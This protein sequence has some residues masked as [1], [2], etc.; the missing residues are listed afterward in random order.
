MFWKL[1]SSDDKSEVVVVD[2]LESSELKDA[3]S[4][5]RSASILPGPPGGG[6][7][8]MPDMPDIASTLDEP[9]LLLELS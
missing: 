9:S 5:S 7:G 3:A 1:L 6:G 2:V 8:G 4:F